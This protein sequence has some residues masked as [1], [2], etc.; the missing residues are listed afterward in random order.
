M[1]L[2]LLLKIP[3]H[4]AHILKMLNR[5]SFKMPYVGIFQAHFMLFL[6]QTKINFVNLNKGKI[7]LEHVPM[8]RMSLAM[9]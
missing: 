1:R 2:V 9:S 7:T 8:G 5:Q 6:I 3:C 4:N